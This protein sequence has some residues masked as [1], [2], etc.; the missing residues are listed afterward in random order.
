LRS[1]LVTPNNTIYVGDNEFVK[2]DG[3]ASG[4]PGLWKVELQ[5]NQFSGEQQITLQ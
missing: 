5:Y 3:T 4:E 2:I 1:V